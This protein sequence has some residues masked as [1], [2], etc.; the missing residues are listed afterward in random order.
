MFWNS[1]GR[2]G[3]KDKILDMFG[4]PPA[5][6]SEKYRWCGTQGRICQVDMPCG[7]WR[8]DDVA[9]LR[10][11]QALRYDMYSRPTMESIVQDLM[12]ST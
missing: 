8:G 5:A 1:K 11:Q 9:L 4:S 12:M 3:I 10:L 2:D 6:M 7:L